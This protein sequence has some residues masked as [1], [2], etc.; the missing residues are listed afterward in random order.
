[1]LMNQVATEYV[2]FDIHPLWNS[3][4]PIKLLDS[5]VTFCQVMY[6]FT[7]WYLLFL[8]TEKGSIVIP[9][10]FQHL[11]L[12]YWISKINYMYYV[13]KKKVE[14]NCFLLKVEIVI[15]GNQVII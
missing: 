12:I 15:S 2:R 10:V 14:I 11:I 7:F 8:A 3:Y 13:L 5:I 6:I 4:D 9:P 1:M